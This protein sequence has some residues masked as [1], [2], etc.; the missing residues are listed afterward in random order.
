[1]RSGLSV[2]ANANSKHTWTVRVFGSSSCPLVLH[3]FERT[4]MAL[5]TSIISFSMSTTV[6]ARQSAARRAA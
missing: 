1:M 4:E 3:A 2:K 5:L 6:P